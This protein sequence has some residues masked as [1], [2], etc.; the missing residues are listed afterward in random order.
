M[1]TLNAT[2]YP[3]E[4]YVL[5]EADWAGTVFRDTFSR[6]SASTWT[7]ADTGQAYT[8]VSGAAAD[9]SINGAQGVVS[10]SGISTD[11]MIIADVNMLNV[12]FS[13]T[14]VNTYLTVGATVELK[15]TIR[16]VDNNNFLD[17]RVFFGAGGP[18]SINLRQRIAGADTI[19]GFPAQ[20]TLPLI[21]VY[22][23][24]LEAVGGEFRFRVWDATL[25]EP[26]TWGLTMATTWL[27]AG[28]IG[29]G[30]SVPVVTATFPLLFLH[31]NLVAVDPTAVM[32]DCAIVTRRNTVTGEIVTLRPYVFY[33]S[34]GALM[35]ECG[36]G[37]WWDTEPPLDVPL[38]YC[39]TACD[40]P[41]ALS[42]NCCFEAGATAPW[43]ATGGVLTSS[44]TFAHEGTSSGLLTPTGTALQPSFTQ[45]LTG[46]LA[47]VPL[48]FSAWI[49]SPQGWNAVMLRMS[50]LYSDGLTE[51]TDTPVE[52]LDDGEWRFLT[53]TITPRLDATATFSFII[54]GTPPNT[55]LFYVDQIAATISIAETATA[56]ETVTVPGEESFWLKSPLHPCLDVAVGICNPM[57]EDCETDSRVSFASMDAESYPPNTVLLSPT[58]R[59]RAIPVNRI[60]QDLASVLR[61]IAHDCDAR[62]AVLAANEPGDPL[63]FQAPALYCIPDRYMSVGTVED[64]RISVDHREPFRLVS[65]PHVKV[66]RPLGPADGICGAQIA[67][68]CDIYA[69]WA[70]L[71]IAGFSWTD[72]LL[73]LASPD[74]PGQPVPPAG[75][76]DWDDVAA[77]FTDWTDVL[78]GGTRDWDEVR[79]GL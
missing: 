33:D 30:S 4:A 42:S 3:A 29:V 44:T 73:G 21:G 19:S 20:P 34:D 26:A 55:T 15:F 74:G 49:M 6:V 45:S 68:L 36:Q 27:T 62:D 56:C 13:G 41:T 23:W 10:H 11:R 53:A 5:V 60:R 25:P 70:A 76:R 66:D 52:I 47:G 64:S 17:A 54:L 2:V 38:E 51:V 61:L 18:L 63:L 40:V 46:V 39:T 71:L 67:D 75:A 48:T 65:L 1:P 77:E 37:L 24:R 12:S 79:D 59:R 50:L 22:G 78:A 31:D 57:I 8:I 9:F 28:D 14:F 35:L 43:V 32:S 16:Y 7:P 69:S 72:L 58:N